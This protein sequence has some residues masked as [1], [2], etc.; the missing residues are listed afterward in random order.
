MT[1]FLFESRLGL[2]VWIVAGVIL[3]YL[4]R[5]AAHEAIRALTRALREGLLATDKLLMAA[6]ERLVSRNTEVLR[7]AGCEAAERAIEREFERVLAVVERD[8]AAYPALHRHLADQIQAIDED[9]RRATEVPP[10]PP[11]WT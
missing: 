2:A 4:G 5:P 6:Q 10:T 8:L 1:D 3:L 7:A 9:Y 11:E